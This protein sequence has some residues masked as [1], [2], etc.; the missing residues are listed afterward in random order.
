[1]GLERVIVAVADTGPIIHL[2]EIDSLDLFS[3]VD[4][5]LIP[6][7]VY[8]ELQ[9]GGLPSELADIDYQL[10][11]ATDKSKWSDSDLDAGE[12]AALAVA[13]G[14]DA[15]LLTDDLDARRAAT[16][17]DIEVHGSIGLI[18]LAHT[19]GKLDRP[20]AAVRMRAL[21]EQTSL[22]I[23]DTIV[24]RGIELLEKSE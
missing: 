14:E 4:K 23:T 12:I 2:G 22:F 17:A 13:S 18:A 5:L 24:E 6:E 21:Q 7:T 11:E 20:T 1:M 8:E 9:A 15:V 16:D 3:V 10:V 19:R